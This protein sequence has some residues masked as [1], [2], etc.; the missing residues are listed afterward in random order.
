MTSL[1]RSLSFVN[2][3]NDMW[4]CKLITGLGL[5]YSLCCI[6]KKIGTKANPDSKMTKLCFTAVFT[7]FVI[8][9]V[10]K[11]PLLCCSSQSAFG[12]FQD[13]LQNYQQAGRFPRD[14]ALTHIRKVVFTKMEC[15]DFCLRNETCDFF[16]LRQVL[17]LKKKRQYWICI[18]QTRLT[19]SYIVGKL[20]KVR[21]W[22]HF[23]VSSHDLH[24]VS[25]AAHCSNLLCH[26]FISII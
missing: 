25:F 5:L 14:E 9:F 10:L 23:N 21:K 13:I 26:Q 7:V 8:P 3:W 20:V 15:L 1:W 16:E 4:N 18:I 2:Y 17:R 6:N 11:I 12:S 24:Q 22:I 19:S